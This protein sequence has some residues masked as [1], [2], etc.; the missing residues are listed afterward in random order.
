MFCQK[1]YSN[2][3]LEDYDGPASMTYFRLSATCPVRR[4]TS[5]RCGSHLAMPLNPLPYRTMFCVTICPH[6][7]RVDL[8]SPSRYCTPDR[9][10]QL[11]PFNYY[12]H[13][14]WTSVF[15]WNG[16][17][18]S[19]NPAW[20]HLLFPTFQQ[21]QQRI[22]RRRRLQRLNPNPA[23][24]NRGS[25]PA[26]NSFGPICEMV[27]CPFPFRVTGGL[28]QPADG[29]QVQTMDTV[30]VRRASGGRKR[31]NFNIQKTDGDEILN[32][33]HVQYQV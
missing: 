9:E 18:L 7:L 5:R 21:T 17:A 12:T 20:A 32:H 16:A 10:V 14:D 3:S 8:T 25:D 4:L 13:K 28:E 11:T 15:L 23:V 27:T 22:H 24:I 6:L 31:E 19:E 1:R 29:K 30:V 26:K 33:P 2:A